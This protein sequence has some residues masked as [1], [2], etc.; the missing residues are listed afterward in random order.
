MTKKAKPRPPA[1]GLIPLARLTPE[2]VERRLRKLVPETLR[3]IK[4]IE[5]AQKIPPE[6]WNLEFDI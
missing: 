2:Q 6:L 4:E 1:K 3:Q 5:D